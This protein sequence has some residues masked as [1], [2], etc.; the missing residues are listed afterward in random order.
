MIQLKKYAMAIAF[1]LL[2]LP[3]LSMAQETCGDQT[4]FNACLA[5]AEQ[6]CST[7]FPACQRTPLTID[8]LRAAINEKCPCDKARN[9]GKYRSCVAQLTGS[10]RKFGLLD[11]ANSALLKSDQETCKAAIKE[12]NKQNKGNK[13]NKEDKGNPNH[14]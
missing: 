3:A 9:Y 8:E 1:V 13:G 14:S 5:A 7:S 10:L 12:R 11:Q 4:G 6:S 2:G